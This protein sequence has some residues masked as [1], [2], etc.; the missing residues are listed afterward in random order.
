MDLAEVDAWAEAN[1]E[2]A[3]NFFEAHGY[4]KFGIVLIG[5]RNPIT[6]E[7][8][9]NPIYVPVM[10]LDGKAGTGLLMTALDI[11]RKSLAVASVVFGMAVNADGRRAVFV[12]REHR[13]GNRAWMAI[14][15]GETLGPFEEE[16][17]KT[18]NWGPFH[19]LLP[20]LD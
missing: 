9:A 8:C 13:T 12:V 14:I 1:C 11:S 18:Q 17:C 16:E 2:V 19:K 15:Q 6:G 4:V 10:S 20:D 5:E 7:N 3:R